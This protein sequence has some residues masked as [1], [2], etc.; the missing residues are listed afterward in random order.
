MS[1]E[2]KYT[3]DGKKVVVIG[4]LNAKENIVQEI[5]VDGDNEIPM[6][7]NFIVKTLLDEPLKSWKASNIEK[8]ERYYSQKE[9][10]LKSLNDKIRKEIPATKEY[11]KA[12]IKH[13]KIESEDFDLLIDFM[14]GS[15]THIV[16]AQYSQYEIKD[17]KKALGDGEYTPKMITLFGRNDDKFGFDY[18]LNYYSDGSGG[19]NQIIPCRS[20]LDALQV[21]AEKVIT[22]IGEEGEINSYQLK[23][24][25]KYD[26]KISKK[27]MKSHYEAII[28]TSKKSLD[29][30]LKETSEIQDRYDKALENSKQP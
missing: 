25:E 17:F 1:R 30:R 2:I 20:Y 26:I 24:I 9:D 27:R 16:H 11:L 3:K 15:I 23:S 19:G 5:Y 28:K 7:E 14:S 29:N 18:N 13:R 8:E 4:A 10:E 6:G 21:L 12:I 22:S